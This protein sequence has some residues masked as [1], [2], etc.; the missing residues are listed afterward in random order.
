MNWI[1]DMNRLT[2]PRNAAEA[3]GVTL[4]VGHPC[5]HRCKLST[6]P[7]TYHPQC[8]D[9]RDCAVQPE[10]I[11]EACEVPKAAWD[12]RSVVTRCEWDQWKPGRDV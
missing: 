2:G 9:R 6:R 11:S 1:A 8:R 4:S 5:A 3:Y 10:A 7:P 12:A